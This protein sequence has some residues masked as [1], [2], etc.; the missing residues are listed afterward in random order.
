MLCVHGSAHYFVQLQTFL[1]WETTAT[2]KCSQKVVCAWLGTLFYATLDIPSCG[3]QHKLYY[4]IIP[5]ELGGGI[6]M[7]THKAM[8]R[9]VS[10]TYTKGM[11][12]SHIINT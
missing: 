11:S 3:V 4:T 2:R 12:V 9:K 5:L 6:H 7:D 8:H 10:N 1:D